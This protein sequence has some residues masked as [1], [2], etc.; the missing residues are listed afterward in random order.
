MDWSDCDLVESVP[1]KVSGAP[2]LIG[3]RLPVEAI[4]GNFDAFLDEGLTESQALAETL[5]CYPDAGIERIK[6]VLEYR[7]IQQH[8]L[9]R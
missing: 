7:A 4:T 8:E 6:S 1:G 2:V 3:T 9:H 5:E